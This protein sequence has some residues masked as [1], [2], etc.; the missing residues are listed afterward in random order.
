MADILQIDPD[1]CKKL[2]SKSTIS[3]GMKLT[4]KYLEEHYKPT[5][6]RGGEFAIR[7]LNLSPKAIDIFINFHKDILSE[8]EISELK[9]GLK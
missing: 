3:L 8:S 5:I 7:D 9:N 2:I 6:Y 4:E 1:S